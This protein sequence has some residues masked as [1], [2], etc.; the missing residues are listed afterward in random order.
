[1]LKFSSIGSGSKGNGT[2]IQSAENLIIVDCGFSLKE[3]ES[4]LAMRAVS[5]HQL[6]AILVTHEHSDHIK[7]V[8]ALAR[9]Y[10]LP[11]HMTYGT[12]RASKLGNVPKLNIIKPNQKFFIGDLE[13]QAVAVP[14]DAREACQFVIERKGAKLGI[15]TDTGHL[16]SHMISAYKGCNALLLECNHDPHLLA[17][18]PYPPSLK[19]RVGGPY[20]HLNNQ[21]AADFLSAIQC[22]KLKHVV[23]THI[24]EQNNQPE[25]AVNMLKLVAPQLNSVPVINQR[26]G[27]DW[28]SID[29]LSE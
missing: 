6:S 16:T 27:L 3:T 8:G 7:G 21:Q 1:M 28:I 17:K 10:N 19:K 23:V 14:H 11:V 9:R 5:A 2:L 24:S 12:H 20:G 22:E 18:G 4:R 25:L 29:H 26:D 13:I 15:L